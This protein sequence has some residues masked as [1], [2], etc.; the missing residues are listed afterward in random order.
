MQNGL[1]QDMMALCNNNGSRTGKSPKFGTRNA[2]DILDVAEEDDE[3]S[4]RESDDNQRF[5]ASH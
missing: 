4:I 3:G 5:D 1:N 2:E